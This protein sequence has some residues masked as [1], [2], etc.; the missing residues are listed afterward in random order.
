MA[1]SKAVRKELASEL[2]RIRDRQARDQKRA[3]AIALILGED[4]ERPAQVEQP[5][6]T[7]LP[8]HHEVKAL[9]FYQ[10]VKAILSEYPTGLTP[11]QV[12]MVA[13]QRFNVKDT[14][15]TPVT[16]LAASA[17]FRLRVRGQ[18]RKNE[19]SQYFLVP[20]SEVQ[21]KATK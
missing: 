20:D 21:M 17:L 4:E 2:S 1:L 11:S 12:A 5:S 6:L 3:D 14:T 15:K 19:N 13:K 18:V 10:I 16:N 7:P 9:N 8:S